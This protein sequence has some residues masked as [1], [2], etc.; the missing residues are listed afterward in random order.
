M[1]GLNDD[2]WAAASIR[3]VSSF[4]DVTALTEHFGIPATKTLKKR[5]I[6]DLGQ[7]QIERGE[8]TLWVIESNRDADRPLAEHL[9]AILPSL[10]AISQ[11]GLPADCR[12][13]VF[14]GSSIITNQFSFIISAAV[15]NALAKVG[16]DI[17]VDLYADTT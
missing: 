11:V 8:V 9:D 16:G 5:K 7:S 12:L 6:L 10:Q 4:L 17:V 1:T 15:V 3:V 2:R 14:L 13:D